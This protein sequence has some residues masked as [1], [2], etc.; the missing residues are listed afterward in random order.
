MQYRIE[1]EKKK[2]MCDL[3]KEWF[4]DVRQ[5]RK[6]LTSHIVLIFKVQ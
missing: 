6:V 5:S 4:L 3:Q 2:S 1:K